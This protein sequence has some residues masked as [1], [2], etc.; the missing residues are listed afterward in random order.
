MP[1][2]ISKPKVETVPATTPIE[3]ILKIIHRDGVIVISD[4]VPEDEVDRLN[5]K[6][7]S[8]FERAEKEGRAQDSFYKNGGRA[9]HTTAAYDLIGS[10][11][12]E[13]TKILQ[14]KA[15]HQIMEEFLTHKSWDWRGE[16]KVYRQTG[17]WLHTT[18]GYKVSPGANNQALHRDLNSAG[19]Q[20]TGPESLV[21]GISTFIAG[22]NVTAK[23]G[24]TH[25]CPGSHLWPQDRAPKQED[26]VAVEMKKG[27][28]AIWLS[29]IF[30]G[31]GENT[32]DPSNPD[33]VRIIY[34]FFAITDNF[35]QGEATAFSC[36]PEVFKKMP[37]EILRL[38]G[39]YAGK[40]GGG[41]FMGRNPVDTW[42]PLKGYSG[43]E[44]FGAEAL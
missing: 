19:I 17:Y 34:G 26:S 39:L 7:V 32:E 23:N 36:K 33:A 22:T 38:L 40:T 4:F 27:S 2:A 1:T 5:A 12:E 8:H 28:L 20:R 13:V 24:G 31:A 44:W 41:R 37:P 3:E 35:R 43:G 30:H 21:N 25:V 42:E 11:P 6:A 29:N 14:R 16:E 18:I 10:C 15:W 9:T